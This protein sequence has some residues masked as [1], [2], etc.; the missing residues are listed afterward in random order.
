MSVWDC[1]HLFKLRVIYFFGV[2][3]LCR[4]KT[5][6]AFFFLSWILK[7]QVTR[8]HCLPVHGPPYGPVHRPPLRVPMKTIIKMTV[9]DFDLPFVL[10]C[11]LSLLPPLL[12]R[13]KED[14]RTFMSE[15]TDNLANLCIRCRPPIA[16]AILFGLMLLVFSHSSQTS[17]IRHGISRFSLVQPWMTRDTKSHKNTFL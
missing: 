7:P 8:K 1:Y 12:W 3:S 4:T 14:L 16:S 2:D 5:W 15:K 6:K 17:K 13:W 9:R 11:F 10:F